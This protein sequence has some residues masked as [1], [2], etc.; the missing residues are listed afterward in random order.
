MTNKNKAGYKTKKPE[1]WDIL[2]GNWWDRMFNRSTG[3]Q[4]L[5]GTSKRGID[6]QQYYIRFR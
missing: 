5:N 6:P 3:I 2:Y 4:T 1:G